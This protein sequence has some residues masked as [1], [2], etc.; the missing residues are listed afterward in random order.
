MRIFTKISCLTAILFSIPGVNASAFTRGG[1]EALLFGYCGN[2]AVSL[3]SSDANIKTEQAAIEIPEELA[4][5]WKG[6]SLTQVHIG[7]GF[8]SVKE[9]TVYLTKDL[10]SE[11][12]YTQT[13]TMDVERGWNTVSLDTPYM[14]E[15]EEFFVGYSVKVNSTAD[16]PIGVDN[17]KTDGKYGDF[18]NTYDEWEN[19][20]KF[21]GNVCIRLSL[22][23]DNLPQYDVAVS[24]LEV[25]SLVEADAPF[26]VSLSIFNN[27]VRTVKSLDVI[28]KIN[29]VE[30]DNP[31]A[32]LPEGEVSSG[33]TGKV[34][35][36]GLKS[37]MIGK[38]LPIE[39]TV[40]K[41]NGEEDETPVDNTVAAA[42]NI[43]DKIY[44]RNVVVEEFTG[45]WC[46]WC[47]LGIVGM[48][49]MEE[50]YGKDGFI[51]IGV[52]FGDEMQ[53]DSYMEFVNRVTGSTAPA[54]FLDR[55]YYF[56][57]PSAETLEG[58]FLEAAAKPASGKIE[59]AAIYSED[60][61][62]LSATSVSEFSFNVTDAKY[63]VA[64]VIIE[65]NFGPYYQLN[66]FSGGGS[67]ELPGWSDNLSR[68]NTYYNEVARDITTAY[69][70]SGS[71][72]SSVSALTPYE[73]SI[74]LPLDN[75]VNIN[76]CEVV[77][78]LLD[79]AT[80][81]IVNAAITT[82]DTGG[83]GVDGMEVS[84]EVL[85]VYN[86]QGVKMLETNNPRDLDNLGEGIYIINGKKVK[87]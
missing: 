52:H 16:K 43:A 5:S 20:G 17:I 83:A 50:K 64:Y 32:S 66:Y 46:G 11:P 30:V 23:G 13:A 82:V 56:L 73:N 6:A 68:V 7:Y 42:V 67:G 14:V 25:P 41:V 57:E 38:D 86:L 40:T 85:K 9:V 78:M 59:V 22:T 27:G 79:T 53:V 2:Y 15:G 74:E 35:I 12:F 26:D 19:I 60:T 21:Y 81:E 55:S 47:P 77:A 75:V 39:I 69:G 29:G 33:T 31:I 48:N 10:V 45:T 58:L 37:G 51:G 70:I 61:N 71:I 65:N 63:A 34:K 49:Y 72:P 76:E 80:G 54:A 44:K 36:S 1:D 28:C 84:E 3:G 4:E 8:S 62:T 18:V 87:L 24:E